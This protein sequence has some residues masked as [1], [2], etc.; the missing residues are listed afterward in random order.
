MDYLTK[1]E[2]A[3]ILKVSVRS[4]EAWA[5]CGLLPYTKISR[6]VRY[7]IDEVRAALKKRKVKAVSE[8]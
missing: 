3:A 7:D 8:R 4:I 6:T 2:L 1:K 5:H